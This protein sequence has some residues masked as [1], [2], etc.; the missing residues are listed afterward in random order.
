METNLEIKNEQLI[1][2]VA[3]TRERENTTLK[4][5]LEDVITRIEILVSTNSKPKEDLTRD[6]LDRLTKLEDNQ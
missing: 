1:K 5:K 2:E 3:A 4:N 6:I